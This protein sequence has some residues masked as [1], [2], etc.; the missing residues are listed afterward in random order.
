MTGEYIYFY[1][2]SLRLGIAYPAQFLRLFRG[3]KLAQGT[4]RIR[5]TRA[6]PL[7]DTRAFDWRK[8]PWKTQNLTKFD[9][10]RIFLYCFISQVERLM[11]YGRVDDGKL[12]RNAFL[13]ARTK[14]GEVVGEDFCLWILH[15]LLMKRVEESICS[16]DL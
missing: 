12:I 14:L 15:R 11:I 8:T 7:R 13:S 6:L 10:R 9:N 2:L 3:K 5:C 16:D 1:P 4:S